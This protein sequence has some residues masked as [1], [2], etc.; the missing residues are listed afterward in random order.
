MKTRFW[1]VVEHILAAI[2][3]S[4]VLFGLVFFVYLRR[5]AMQPVEPREL[6]ERG[7]GPAVLI[8][9]QGSAYKNAIVDTLIQRLQTLP[10]YL[11]IIDISQLPAVDEQQWDALV[12]LHSWE[13][14]QPPPA[15]QGFVERLKARSKLVVLTTSGGGD[16]RMACVDAVTSASELSRTRA[17]GDE[18]LGRVERVLGTAASASSPAPSHPND[19]VKLQPRP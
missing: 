13:R 2:G 17:D 7:H 10:T 19:S 16:S 18:L 5:H 4:A 1:K 14:W 12:V 8:A 9:T 11:R 3:A 6:G 15:V